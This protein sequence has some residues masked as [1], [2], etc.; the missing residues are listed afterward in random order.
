MDTMI[1]AGR[2]AEDGGGGMLPEVCLQAYII[3]HNN[4]FVLSCSPAHLLHGALVAFFLELLGERKLGAGVAPELLQAVA[5]VG[6]S[7]RSHASG[8]RR[9]TRGT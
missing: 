2:R 4:G 9:T 1:K 3:T 5:L 6:G 8:S 7:L